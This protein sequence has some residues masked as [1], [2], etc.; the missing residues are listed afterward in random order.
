MEKAS[1]EWK[2]WVGDCCESK[3]EVFG[4]RGDI[5]LIL[6]EETVRHR[7]KGA[8]RGEVSLRR[9]LNSGLV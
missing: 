8:D 3:R 1:W 2:G 4:G 7:G 9:W 5:L 6:D